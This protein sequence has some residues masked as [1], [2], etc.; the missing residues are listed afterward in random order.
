MA[1]RSGLT[2]I[3]LIVVLSILAGVVAL[4]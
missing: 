4:A 3:E 2:L 1:R